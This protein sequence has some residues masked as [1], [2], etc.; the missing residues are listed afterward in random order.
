MPKIIFCMKQPADTQFKTVSMKELEFPITQS[1]KSSEIYLT[2]SNSHSKNELI[3]EFI[4]TLN[5]KT[6]S[7]INSLDDISFIQLSQKYEVNTK[8]DAENNNYDYWANVMIKRLDEIHQLRNDRTNILDKL[9]HDTDHDV[10]IEDVDLI[11]QQIKNHNTEVDTICTT[12]NDIPYKESIEIKHIDLVCGSLKRVGL[13]DEYVYDSN[14][15]LPK[16]E[17]YD[18]VWYVQDYDDKFIDTEKSSRNEIVSS[19]VCTINTPKIRKN[20]KLKITC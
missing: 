20:A 14:R 13:K 5:G 18:I 17:I 3:F 16:E 1:N 2:F 19:R 10:S 6:E 7:D 8:F 11:T 4:L 9:D 15:R 12:S